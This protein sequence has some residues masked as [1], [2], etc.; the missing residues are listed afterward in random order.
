MG[1]NFQNGTFHLQFFSTCVQ[2]DDE[3][4]FLISIYI[5]D[6][7][8]R[9]GLFRFNFFVRVC[10]Q[11]MKSHS[12]Y[13]FIHRILLL[14]WD[15]SDSIFLHVCACTRMCPILNLDLYI[16]I[17]FQNGTFC[18]RSQPRVPPKKVPW[19]S[20][21]PFSCTYTVKFNTLPKKMFFLLKYANCQICIFQQLLKVP[22]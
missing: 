14:E 1:F 11:G 7:T 2:A 13:R 17:N 22:I 4:P 5:Q 10:R 16:G 20:R 8:F 15:F 3:V 6:L 18:A 19:Q 21:V 12:K 9:M